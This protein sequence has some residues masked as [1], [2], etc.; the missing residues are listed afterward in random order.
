MWTVFNFLKRFFF[1]LCRSIIFAAF[2]YDEKLQ[3]TKT[4]TQRL[5]IWAAIGIIV[6]AITIGLIYSTW[7]FLDA[8]QVSGF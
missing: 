3:M 7:Y 1:D 6:L 5:F 8:I 4:T 2:E